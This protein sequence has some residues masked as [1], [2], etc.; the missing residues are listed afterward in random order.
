M[1]LFAYNNDG[2]CMVIADGNEL[3][4][5]SGVDEVPLWMATLGSPIV[6]VQD[7]GSQIVSLEESGE[8]ALW[9]ASSGNKVSSVNVGGVSIALSMAPG[10]RCAVVRQ[11]SVVLA[12]PNP[13]TYSREIEV[14]QPTSAAWSDDGTLLAIGLAEGLLRVYDTTQMQLIGAIKTGTAIRD[15]TWNVK[16]VWLVTGGELI[17]EVARDAKSGHPLT[18]IPNMAPSI[19]VCSPDGAKFAVQVADK[20]MM[21]LNYSS[22][23]IISQLRYQ[24]RSIV[25]LAFGPGD[26]YGV[27][28]D[29]GDA[30]KFNIATKALHR[31]DPHPGRPLNRWE[32]MYH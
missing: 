5:H 3:L 26:W 15:V 8:L 24:D 2:S 22:K 17:F 27:G 21:V 31:T 10:G 4:V 30:N 12:E 29:K 6:G 28:M 25:G 13:D 20:I 23:D 11:D 9:E 18:K 16:G 1:S 19:I 14:E 32:V 7:F